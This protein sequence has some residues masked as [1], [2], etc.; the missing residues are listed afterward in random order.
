MR[1][2]SHTLSLHGSFSGA[3]KVI[4]LLENQTGETVRAIQTDNGSG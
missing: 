2:D 3:Q 1:A 4:R